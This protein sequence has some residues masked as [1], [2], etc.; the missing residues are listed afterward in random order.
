M[1]NRPLPNHHSSTHRDTRPKLTV[2]ANTRALA[3]HHMRTKIHSSTNDSIC[4]NHSARP[5]ANRLTDL[6]R[7]I[8]DCAGVNDGGCPSLPS[9]VASQ[10]AGGLREE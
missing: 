9:L 8:D 1:D 6:C 2:F 10:K 3:H 4:L 5:N 7:G